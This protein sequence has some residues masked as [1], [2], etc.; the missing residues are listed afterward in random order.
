MDSLYQLKIASVCSWYPLK[1]LLHY[2]PVT[3]VTV[4]YLCVCS[5][6]FISLTQNWKTQIFGTDWYRQLFMLFLRCLAYGISAFSMT[7]LSCGHLVYQP[8]Q[9]L[10]TV[11]L[12]MWVVKWRSFSVS[13]HRSIIKV[14]TWRAAWFYVVGEDR[15]YNNKCYFFLFSRW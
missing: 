1:Q 10:M 15:K 11:N 12:I 14:V 5:F 4:S 8:F 9:V 2:T 6:L 13:T 3:L 7:L